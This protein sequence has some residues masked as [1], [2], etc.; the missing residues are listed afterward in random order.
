MRLRRHRLRRRVAFGLL[1]LVA[2]AWEINTLFVP[3]TRVRAA[4][5]MTFDVTDFADGAPVGQTFRMSSDGL[6]SVDLQFSVDRPTSLLLQ[7]QLLTWND[8]AQDHWAIVYKWTTT[9]ELAAGRRSSRFSFTPVAQSMG[10]VFQFRVQ[11][12][13]ARAL[14]VN[15]GGARPRVIVI[16]S[17][18]D[19]LTDGNLVLGRAQLVD[20]DL[21]FQAYGADSAIDVFRLRNNLALPK[22]LRGRMVQIALLATYT[23]A[24]AVFA[25][26]MLV[27]LPE[28]G[29][30]V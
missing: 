24:L 11:Q 27:Q 17:L 25:Y 19:A 6:Q 29:E 28:I 21:L 2:V 14:Q 20:R 1:F 13:E 9:V 12:L 5:R 26:Y 16:G 30:R 8:Y 4:G 23:L 7:C 22:P 18:D 3:G 10:Q 15:A